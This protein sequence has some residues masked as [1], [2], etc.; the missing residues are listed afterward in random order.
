MQ[1]LR[2]R[3]T[4]ALLVVL[5]PLRTA[6][7]QEPAPVEVRV[8]PGGQDWS[9]G[10]HAGSAD[11]G[12]CLLHLAP[13][14]YHVSMGET[15][16]DVLIDVPS[17]VAYRPALPALRV[18]GWVLVGAGLAG[19]ALATYGALKVCARANDPVCPNG[20][21][22]LSTKVALAS[23]AGVSFGTGVVGGFLVYVAGGSIRVR[24]LP[25]AASGFTLDVSPR[26]AALGWSFAF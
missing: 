21:A 11:C 25:R 13:R 12:S 5:A 4:W 20:S 2:L 15:S 7:A 3:W 18:V 10:D 8:K 6:W 26:G 16:E 19:G 17:E 14:R 23:I 24:D 9:I 22:P 1:P